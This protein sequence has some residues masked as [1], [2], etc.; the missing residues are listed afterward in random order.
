MSAHTQSNDYFE[1]LISYTAR[2][3]YYYMIYIII[4]DV[5]KKLYLIKF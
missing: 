4:Y 3:N 1:N 2:Y 5:N